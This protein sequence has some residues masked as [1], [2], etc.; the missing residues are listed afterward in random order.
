[1][2]YPYP[3]SGDINVDP[4]SV[5][6]PVYATRDASGN[7][8]LAIPSSSAGGD[9]Y[10]STG[11]LVL[12]SYQRPQYGP[13]GETMRM[14]NR[15]PQAKTMIAWYHPADPAE[16]Y[17]AATNPMHTS[18]DVWIGA[19]YAAQDDEVDA[20]G[21]WSL[22]VPDDEG[23][24]RSRFGIDWINQTTKARGVD[25]THAYFANCDLSHAQGDGAIFRVHS[26]AGS[27]DRTIEFSAYGSTGL[28]S[29][30]YMDPLKRR[31]HLLANQTAE[32]GSNA[33][34]DF[35]IRRFADNGDVLGTLLFAKRST[36]QITLGE[37]NAE[38]ARLAIRWAGGTV[39]H[40]IYTYPDA[41][42]SSGKA[43]WGARCATTS[44]RVMDVRLGSD[45]QSRF[46]MSGVGLMEWGDG[47]AA[48]DCTFYRVGAA[49]LGVS[50]CDLEWAATGKGPVIRSPDGTKYR[51][52]VANGGA[53]STVAA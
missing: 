8:E 51:I 40:G 2:T 18:A 33:G 37:L 15:T 3:W 30:G 25:K 52:T 20:H 48:I 1:M 12:E 22:E 49:R 27:A 14:M 23:H 24:L 43:H 35:L 36:G 26:G 38:A 17:D 11:R 4:A 42:P 7:V 47:T 34:T 39:D 21:H 13:Y 46:R 44:D 41:A 32:A 16:N 29:P 50:G 53:L 5:P 10:D 9:D 19:H 45:A 28:T 31:W 6:S